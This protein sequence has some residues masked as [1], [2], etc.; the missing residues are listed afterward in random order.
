M[1]G[2]SKGRT[3][4]GARF[5][6]ATLVIALILAACGTSSSGGSTASY[7]DPATVSGGLGTG[8]NSAS[9][10]NQALSTGPSGQIAASNPDEYAAG[11]IQTYIHGDTG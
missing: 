10:A 7:G 3:L 6:V 9:T 11:V 4:R 1:G 8:I 2:E 5:A